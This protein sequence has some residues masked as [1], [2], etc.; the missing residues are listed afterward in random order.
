MSEF[1]AGDKVLLNKVENAFGD[2]SHHEE[3]PIVV[4]LRETDHSSYDFEAYTLDGEY[5]SLVFAKNVSKIAG[6]VTKQTQIRV[7][8]GNISVSHTTNSKKNRVSFTGFGQA[9]HIKFENLD[10]VIALLLKLKEEV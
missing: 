2:L 3:L 10:R 5:Y 9:G 8:D 7:S 1:K 6:E 4:E